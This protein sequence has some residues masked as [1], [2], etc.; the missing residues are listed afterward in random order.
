MGVMIEGIF[1][2]GLEPLL[3]TL[4]E[5]FADEG[6]AREVAIVS[7]GKA[8]LVHL[9]N[10]PVAGDLF[11]ICI[12]IPPALHQQLGKQLGAY[13]DRLLY[14]AQR[15]M[16]RHIK[17]KLEKVSLAP[18][19]SAGRTWRNEARAWLSVTEKVAKGDTRRAP[20]PLPAKRK[21]PEKTGTVEI[22][23]NIVTNPHDEDPSREDTRVVGGITGK[24]KTP[25]PGS[26]G[27]LSGD[28]APVA[29][30]HIRGRR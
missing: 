7:T 17:H 22:R 23:A 28:A 30:V 26:K 27:A 5:H 8:S 6:A 11:C 3:A 9:R 25:K 19:L 2:D 20:A 21:N 13:E 29:E 16:P 14:R 15:L 24:S 4:A 12:R 18:A 1:P 10:D